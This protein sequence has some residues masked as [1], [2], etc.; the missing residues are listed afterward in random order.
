MPSPAKSQVP[1]PPAATLERASGTT[2]RGSSDDALSG[3]IRW[4]EAEKNFSPHTVRN[5]LNG[6]VQLQAL[7]GKKPLVSLTHQDIRTC[8]ARL[9]G[10]SLDG[11]TIALHLS[12][13]R[14]FFGWLI[15]QKQVGANPAVGVRAPRVARPLPKALSPDQMISYLDYRPAKTQDGTAQG[16]ASRTAAKK[17]SAKQQEA[18]KRAAAIKQAVAARDA[19]MLELFYSCG[20]RLA[21]LVGLD[22]HR[23]ALSQ[24]VVDRAAGE[25]HVR[26][27]GNKTRRVR[28]TAK[29]MAALALWETQR[30]VLAKRAIKPQKSITVRRMMPENALFI[31][32]SGRRIARTAVALAVRRRGVEA[33]IPTRVHPHMLRHSFASHVL[34]SSGDLRAVQEMLG[35]ASLAA[36]QVYTHLDFQALAKVYDASHPRAKRTGSKASTGTSGAVKTDVNAVSQAQ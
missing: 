1:T 30:E 6:V 12:T 34:Q 18:A 11:R 24:G 36:T 23:T 19:A 17:T 4:M 13:W 25:V 16:K 3:F 29:A 5:Y 15:R 21:E 32:I 7:V 14:A 8:V 10:R 27:K 26:G 33:G 9:A 28:L 31:G 20:L 22:T 35:H 2:M